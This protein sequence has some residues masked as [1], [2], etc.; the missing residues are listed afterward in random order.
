MRVA[1][2]T[3]WSVEVRNA[4]LAVV[5]ASVIVHLVVFKFVRAALWEPLRLRRIMNKQGVRG[6]P[7]KFLLGQYMDM[8]RFSESFPET[9]AMD[10]LANLSPTVTPQYAMYFPKYG[11]YASISSSSYIVDSDWSLN[12]FTF[13]IAVSQ[14]S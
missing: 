3:L 12:E 6:P 9:L 5:V 14:T 4:V 7:F 8:V 2:A 1:M 13:R 10:E 11:A